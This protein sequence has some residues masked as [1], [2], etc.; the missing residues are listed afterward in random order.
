M[1]VDKGLLEVEITVPKSFFPDEELNEVAVN[2]EGSEM[3]SATVNSDDTIT[4]KMSKA[5]NKELMTEMKKTSL[6]IRMI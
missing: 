6:N 1:A 4:Y 3:K 5:K 2:A